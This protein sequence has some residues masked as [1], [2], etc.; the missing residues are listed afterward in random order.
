MT[1][2]HSNYYVPPRSPLPIIG[3]IGLFLFALG[4][5]NFTTLWGPGLFII[6]LLVLLGMI[7]SWFRAVIRESRQG[8]YDAQMQR[9]F[10]WGMF[11]FIFCEL[12]LFGI[13]LGALIYIRWATLPSLAGNGSGGSLLTHYL[14]WPDFQKTWPLLKNPAPYLF[15]GGNLA[16]AAWGIPTLNTLLLLSS[17]ILVTWA[18]L[19]SKKANRWAPPTGLLAAILLGIVFLFLQLFYY[20]EVISIYKFT[21]GSGIYGSLFSILT[22]VH[23]LHVLVGIFI[24]SVVLVRYAAG[25]FSAQN[26]FAFEAAIWFWLLIT[27][28]W[29]L[30]FMFLYGF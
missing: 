27:A 11:W 18:F 16:P 20:S 1:E 29:L 15:A 4:S 28:L 14:L 24:L 17:A 30:I 25:H 23:M 12:F 5:L 8:L 7:F 10:R 26:N 13:L 9:S 2:N 21:I 22:V 19:M 6:G 3:A